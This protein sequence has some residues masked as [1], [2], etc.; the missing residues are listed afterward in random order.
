M[1]SSTDT[2]PALGVDLPE[3][4]A[5]SDKTGL[6]AYDRKFNFLTQIQSCMSVLLDF[7]ACDNWSALSWPSGNLYEQSEAFMLPWAVS[8]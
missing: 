4:V 8:K 5:W 1:S 7:I 2:T 3:Y 6:I